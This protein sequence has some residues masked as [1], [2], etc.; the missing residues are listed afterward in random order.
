VLAYHA[1][2][3]SADN[4]KAS[5]FDGALEAVVFGGEMSQTGL[6]T[7]PAVVD[8]AAGTWH[9]AAFN[10]LVARVG[11]STDSTPNSYWDSIWSRPR[12][13]DLSGTT[14]HSPRPQRRRRPGSS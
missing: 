6:S 4:G 3:S 5:I 11:Y 1:A 7:R 14:A 9:Q 13:P 10:G 8:P 12:S 2:G